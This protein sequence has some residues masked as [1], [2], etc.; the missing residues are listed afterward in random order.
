MGQ[1][2][3]SF[4]GI[5]M[6]I[7]K[8]SEVLPADVQHRVVAVDASRGYKSPAG[9]WGDLPPHVSFIEAKPDVI[10]ALLNAGL[11]PLSG[12]KDKRVS[13]H[14]WSVR[15]V[16]PAGQH[17]DI[18]LGDDVFH[19]K[20]ALP[21]M[22]LKEGIGNEVEV[23]DWAASFVD[24]DSGTVT[25]AK[26]KEGGVYTTWSVETE[27][28]PVLEFTQTQGGVIQPPLRVTIPSTPPL[29]SLAHR[30]PGSMVLHNGTSDQSDKEWDF[31]LYYLAN[32]Q[33]IP[34]KNAIKL[35]FPQDLP[36]VAPHAPI[37]RFDL[38]TSCSNSQYP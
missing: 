14:G 37:M 31:V 26:F 12:S 17:A 1:F 11:P 7:R 24:I 32:R 15:L 29:A 35:I 23:P 28:D 4:R 2:V 30:V 8:Q 20:D 19:L 6:H 33:G 27:G 10:A 36:Q 3:M 18:R 21:G 22:V 25:A 9:E 13:L 16:N 5:N 38:T 34:P